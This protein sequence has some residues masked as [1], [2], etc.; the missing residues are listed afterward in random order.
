M[1]LP[2][3]V[4]PEL[5][6]ITVPYL[7]KEGIELLMM[8]FDNTVV[9]YTTSTPTEKIDT[10]LKTMVA[11]PVK[12]C[13]VSNSRKSRVQ[14]FCKQYGI[15]CIIRAKKPGT[16]GINECLEKYGLPKEKCA[17]VGD[18]IYTDTLGGNRAGV[19]V[20]L[21]KSIHNHNIWLKLRHVAEL[22]LIAI[23]NKRR[24]PNE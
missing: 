9:P 1:L 23:A 14:I 6:D 10:W 5:T 18:Q 16:K 13:V 24:I 20:I 4:T 8:D 21:V 11:S 3:A 17:L 22:P 15:D 12:L 7:Q 2:Y 19:R